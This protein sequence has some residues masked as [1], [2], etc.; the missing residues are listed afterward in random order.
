M[1]YLIFYTDANPG[2]C[3][4]FVK[5]DKINFTTLSSALLKALVFALGYAV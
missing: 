3:P 4:R 2:F 5:K 1:R